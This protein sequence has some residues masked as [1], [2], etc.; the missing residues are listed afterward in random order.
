MKDVFEFFVEGLATASE[1]RDRFGQILL[2]RNVPNDAF[3]GLQSRLDLLRAQVR[4]CDQLLHTLRHLLRTFLPFHPSPLVKCR[5]PRDA[6]ADEGTGHAPTAALAHQQHQLVLDLDEVVEVSARLGR[7][8][9]LRGHVVSVGNGDVRGAEP[10]GEQGKQTKIVFA[11]LKKV[12]HVQVFEKATMKNM[13][14]KKICTLK[15]VLP[16]MSMKMMSKLRTSHL[17]NYILLFIPR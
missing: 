13:C 9:V 10:L 6:L 16:Y 11:P 2:V 17:L 3:V 8:N 12:D 14:L 7:T 5:S 15:I 4:R 1:A